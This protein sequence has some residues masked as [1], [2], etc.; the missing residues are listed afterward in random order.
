VSL[1]PVFKR[2]FG[3]DE[4]THLGSGWAAGVVSVLAGLLAL[5][6]VL[7]FHF[8]GLLSAPRFRGL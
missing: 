7:C 2:L 1:D 4:P 5:G 8:P 6:G 3:D